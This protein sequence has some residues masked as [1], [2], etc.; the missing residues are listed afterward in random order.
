MIRMVERSVSGHDLVGPTAVAP[1]SKLLISSSI[2]P[3]LMPFGVLPLARGKIVFGM[4]AGN[5]EAADRM[6]WI[7][8]L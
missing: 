3:E 7:G 2:L 4:R 8:N 6:L 1:Q 5:S